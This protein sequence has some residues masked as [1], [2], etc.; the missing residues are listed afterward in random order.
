MA[1]VAKKNSKE[2]RLTLVSNFAVRENKKSRLIENQE[3]LKLEL[4]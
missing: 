2:N 3:T 1:W 4:H